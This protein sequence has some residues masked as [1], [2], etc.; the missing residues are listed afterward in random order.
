[1]IFQAAPVAKPLGSV[2][3]ICQVGHIVVFDHDGSY[4]YNKEYQ[5]LNWMREDNGNYMLDV[6]QPLAAAMDQRSWQQ[7]H[8]GSDPRSWSQLPFG[9]QP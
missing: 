6:W 1:M 7:P 8:Y 2:K 3:K 4:V 9:R 5:E